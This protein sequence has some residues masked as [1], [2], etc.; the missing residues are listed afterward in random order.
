MKWD[1]L[2]NSVDKVKER[3]NTLQSDEVDKIKEK[4]NN[5]NL[6]LLDFRE[7]FVEEAP[8]SYEIEIEDAY[9]DIYKFHRKINQVFSYSCS[10]HRVFFTFFSLPFSSSLPLHHVLTLL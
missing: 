6:E 9:D 5:F 2:V 8:F 7:Q 4:V 1:A 10:A 3:V